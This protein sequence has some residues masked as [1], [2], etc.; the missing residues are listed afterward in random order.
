MTANQVLKLTTISV[1]ISDLYENNL[2]F[3]CQLFTNNSKPELTD[4]EDLTIYL[5]VL[6]KEE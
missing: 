2:L 6:S 5:Y 1:T 3:V 4:Q